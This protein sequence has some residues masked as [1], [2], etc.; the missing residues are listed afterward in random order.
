MRK[1]HGSE[2]EDQGSGL[3]LANQHTAS[4]ESAE[5]WEGKGVTI[6]EGGGT[7]RGKC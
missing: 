6:W 4:K 1:K 7:L 2:D 5:E 3:A